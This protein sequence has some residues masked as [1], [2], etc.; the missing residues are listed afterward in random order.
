LQFKQQM[1]HPC[2][3]EYMKYKTI[4]INY[5][6]IN[7][8]WISY[9]ND[10]EKLRFNIHV[11]IYISARLKIEYQIEAKPETK[12][13]PLYIKRYEWETEKNGYLVEGEKAA[14]VLGREWFM[15]SLDGS[16]LWW[17]VIV[18]EWFNGWWC[19]VDWKLW[20]MVIFYMVVVWIENC[21]EWLEVWRR[22]WR[23]HCFL[24]VVVTCLLAFVLPFCRQC[25]VCVC[26]L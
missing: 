12:Q 7:Q 9:D 21:G 5:Q 25:Y 15:D 11:H 6:F 20:W 23:G 13:H 14:L 8:S 26:V 2:I 3:Y 22:K 24:V 16:D 18:V 1:I 10:S 17:Y 4:G 19:S